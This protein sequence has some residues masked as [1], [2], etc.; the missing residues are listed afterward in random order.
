MENAPNGRLHHA[1]WI[2]THDASV[3]EMLRFAAG[4]L[5]RY[6]TEITGQ[7]WQ[8]GHASKVGGTEGEIWLGL[9]NALAQPPGRELQPALWDDGYIVWPSGGCLLIAGK[10]ARSVLFGVYAFLEYQGVRYLRPSLD[11]E[12]VPKRDE[13]A[14]PAEPIAQEATYRH[15]GLCI[16]GASSLE[17]ALGMVDWCAKKRM[18]TFFLQFFTSRYFYQLWYAR[19]YNPQFAEH[20]VTD[21]D[22]AEFDRAIVANLKQRGMVY[23]QVGHGWT[24]VTLGLPRSGW[25]RTDEQV[26]EERTRWLAEVEGSRQLHDH[27]PINT[28]LCYSHQPAFDALVES[29]VRYCQAHP[30]LDVVHVWLSDA[31]NNKCECADCRD[32][33]ISD[34]YA[35]IINAIS[36]SL[37]RRAPGKRFVF[38]CYI[39][40]LW[41]P[42][43]IEIDDRYD[44]II[45]MYAPITR[46]YGHPLLDAECGDGRAYP[47]PVLN[48]YVAPRTNGFFARSLAGWRRAF[49]GDSFDFDYHLMWAS[50]K[51]LTDTVVAKTLYQDLQNL[52]GAGLNGILSCQSLRNFSP[53]GLAM[54]V[55][56]DALWDPSIPWA[57]MRDAYLHAA[58]GE[59]A[60]HVAAYL[61]RLEAIW[62]PAIHTG[63]PRPCRQRWKR[64]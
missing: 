34:W 27:M 35:K 57:Q 54:A 6:A 16:E 5:A 15:R 4:E 41:A 39:E 12:V 11:G 7:D 32:L 37:H 49:A 20:D 13:L 60:P 23:H 18:N 25:V 48:A 46:C 14:W 10:N 45:M 42:E 64:A 29:V 17:H 21:E 40:L 55:L 8:V 28:E 19:P 63:E 44:N 51:H 30:E 50:W 61:D 22:A 62:I 9:C 52:Q 24:A 36:E 1:R 3:D 26:S 31:A 33:P 59:D 43:R 47:R 53:S 58:F 56:A 2:E 38:L